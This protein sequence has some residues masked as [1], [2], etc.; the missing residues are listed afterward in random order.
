MITSFKMEFYEQNSQF[1]VDYHLAED[2][3][4]KY[5]VYETVNQR[6]KITF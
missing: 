1:H 4:A 5:T 3:A 2:T 6:E